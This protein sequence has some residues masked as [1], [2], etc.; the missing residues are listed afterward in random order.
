MTEKGAHYLP[1]IFASVAAFMTMFYMMRLMYMT[2]WGEPKNKEKYDHAHES[3]PVMTIPLVALAV[4]A[5]LA[6]GTMLPW[7]TAADTWY[8]QLVQRPAAAAAAETAGF[9]AIRHKFNELHEGM[10][11]AAHSAHYGALGVSLAMVALGFV[12]AWLF[13]GKKKL[14][15]ERAALAI[16]PV[17]RTVVNKYYLDDFNDVVF[18]KGLRK[19][20]N[21]MRVTVEALIDFIVNFMGYF[22]RFVSFTQGLV[23]KYI[24]DGLVNF[25][26]W[27]SHLLAGMFRVLQ[28]GNTKDY[29]GLALLGVVI[30]ALVMLFLK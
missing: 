24:V 12:L 26:W 18:V 2:F 19:F 23:D 20:C 29:L 17:Y 15:A 9:P 22:I 30:I 11:H 4:L 8:G 1:F 14:S 13:Y 7:K 28:T 3:P 16:G 25:W 6:A 21:I 10:E 27:F 5:V